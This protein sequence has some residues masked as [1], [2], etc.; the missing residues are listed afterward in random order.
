MP[1]GIVFALLAACCYAGGNLC[2]ARGTVRRRGDN[3]AMLA[4]MLTAVAAAM[5]WGLSGGGLPDRFSPDLWIG[6]VWFVVAG[7]AGTVLA[8]IMIYRSIQ[9]VGVSASTILN[10]LNPFFAVLLGV[11]VL[12]VALSARDILGIAV[13]AAAVALLIATRRRGAIGLT[14]HPPQ[15]YAFGVLAALGY[16]SANVTRKLGLD[17]LPDPVFGALVAALAGMAFYG[18]AAPFVADYRR[19]F[20]GLIAA[21][22]P[23]QAGAAAFVSAGQILIFMALATGAFETV[24]MLMSLEVFLSMLLSAHL[25]RLEAPLTWLSWLAAATAVAGA[26]LIATGS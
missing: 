2:I 21:P 26:L 15:A 20:V 12:G 19:A 6:L 5:L 7:L 17:A 18:L 10:R 8:R 3:G 9:R 11:P 1:P 24:V 22:N 13:L 16:G 25:F 4:T 14:V 23:W